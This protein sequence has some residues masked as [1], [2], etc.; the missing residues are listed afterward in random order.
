MIILQRDKN[1]VML[2]HP[3]DS[4]TW[5][6]E[7]EPVKMQ[8]WQ[9]WSLDVWGNDEDGFNVNDRYDWG[10]LQLP[11]D[12]SDEVVI[13]TIK[14]FGFFTK[15]AVVGDFEIDGDDSIIYITDVDTGCP[16]CELVLEEG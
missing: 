16:L 15:D 6:K 3:M 4:L 10:F 5:F 2:K 14:D 12:V 9:V 8:K 1:K 13:R 11:E 7:T